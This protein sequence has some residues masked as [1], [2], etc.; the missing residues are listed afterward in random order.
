MLART[1]AV[2][3]LP[4]DSE[5]TWP[6]A[7]REAARAFL[8]ASLSALLREAAAIP[9]TLAQAARAVALG[10]RPL[11]V[12]TAVDS[13]DPTTAASQ[14]MTEEQARRFRA[15]WKTLHDDEATWSSDSRH[16][17]VPRTS[18]FIQLKRP[19][20]VIRAVRDVVARSSPS[21]TR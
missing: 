1:G 20:V 19:D 16:E 15:T 2:R 3:L 14:G 21:R 12:L 4:D 18:H 6:R 7:V 11:A 5:P 17:L 8:P 9:A 10:D 13:P